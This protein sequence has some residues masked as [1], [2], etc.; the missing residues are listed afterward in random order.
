MNLVPLYCHANFKYVYLCL[1]LTKN[2]IKILVYC[3]LWKLHITIF[4]QKWFT[5]SVLSPIIN[6]LLIWGIIHPRSSCKTCYNLFDDILKMLKNLVTTPLSFNVLFCHLIRGIYF[7]KNCYVLDDIVH[8]VF[9]N[10]NGKKLRMACWVV[11]Y[12]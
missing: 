9:M 4:G 12:W 2:V 8:V 7:V 10:L 5:S 11:V 1:R 6:M 3:I